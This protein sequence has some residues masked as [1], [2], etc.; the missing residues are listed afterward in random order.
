MKRSLL[1]TGLAIA[2]LTL[3][4]LMLSAQTAKQDIKD[5][6]HDTADAARQTGH[7]VKHGTKHAAHKAARHTRHGAEKVEDKTR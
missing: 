7:K 4:P 6:G 3:L 1:A 5:A 2:S